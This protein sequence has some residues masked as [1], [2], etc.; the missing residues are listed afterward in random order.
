MQAHK[1]SRKNWY[2][3]VGRMSVEVW[4]TSLMWTSAKRREKRRKQ[5]SLEI[6]TLLALKLKER[7]F[8]LNSRW[9][10]DFYLNYLQCNSFDRDPSL[11]EKMWRLQHDIYNAAE[12]WA[13][14]LGSAVAK[15]FQAS[16][17]GLGHVDKL[18]RDMGLQFGSSAVFRKL[19]YFLAVIIPRSTL[20]RRSDAWNCSNYGSNS[21][22]V[23]AHWVLQPCKAISLALCNR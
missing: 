12:T 14:S 10:C 8:C 21:I 20:G 2:C 18:L 23:R 19:G 11:F 7:S 9:R 17:I 1:N 16:L 5:W 4:K 15:S 3:D 13:T 22:F 6:K